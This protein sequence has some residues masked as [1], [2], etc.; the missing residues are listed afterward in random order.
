LRKRRLDLGLLQK[1]VAAEIGVD[2]KTLCNWEGQRT[3]PEIRFLPAIFRF[4]GSDPRPPPTTLPE[5][6]QAARTALGLSQA[7]L[8]RRIGIDPGT[9]ARWEA[10]KGRPGGKLSRLL[11]KAQILEP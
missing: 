4:L 1:Q 2:L 7:A 3:E 10:G 9:V 8:A 5:R 11:T 6:F